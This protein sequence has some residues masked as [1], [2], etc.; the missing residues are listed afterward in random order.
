MPAAGPASPPNGDP[1]P[2]HL[3]LVAL[4]ALVTLVSATATAT[5]DAEEVFTSQA[6]AANAIDSTWIP[7]PP[8]PAA[9]C[10]VDTGND[11]N[12]DTSN[13]IARFSVDGGDPGDLSPDH[14]GTLMSMIAAAPYNGFGMVGAAP[15]IN[16][17]SVRASRDGRTFGGTD[18]AAAIKICTLKR[19]AYNIKAVSLSLGGQVVESIDAASMATVENLVNGARRAGLNVLAAAGNGSA[20]V[21]WPAG[22]PEVLAV[23]A[24]D[25]VGGRCA[26]ASFGPEID[27]W[28]PG[29][30]MDVAQPNGLSA[31]AYGSSESTVYVAAVLTQMRHLDPELSLDRAEGILI[32]SAA[33]QTAGP[34]LDVAHAYESAGLDAQLALGRSLAAAVSRRVPEERV[35]SQPSKPVQAPAEPGPRLAVDPILPS[36]RESIKARTP[37]RLSKPQ[38]Q[39]LRHAAGVLTLSLR[40]KPARVVAYVTVYTRSRRAEFADAKRI[41]RLK[42]KRL[43]IRVLGAIRQVSVVYRDP[44]RI[45][46]M[47]APLDVRI[48]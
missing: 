17:V 4:I 28:A 19:T 48:S 16:I 23:G 8:K 15:S 22:Y 33:M 3:L 43:R 27:L 6:A 47:S 35:P 21:D 44:A 12:P 18:L 10:I 46:P 26:F 25:D 7:A 2:R 39:R 24:A 30:P 29:C 36:N 32:S 31:W 13:V 34:V 42:T 20:G 38:I 5:A 41:V 37:S 40:N 14:H 1:P 9:L 45:C 11:L